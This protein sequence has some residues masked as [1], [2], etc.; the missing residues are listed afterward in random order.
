MKL[1][2]RDFTLR[3]KIL[4]L[5]LLVILIA[6]CYYQ[7]VHVP[8]SDS[9]EKEADRKTELETELQAVNERIALFEKMQKELDGITTDGTLKAMPSYNN[10]K[11]VTKLLND[12]LGNL[13]YNIRLT[14]VKRTNDLVRRQISL[15]FD[16]PDFESVS[17]VFAGLT[18]SEYRCLLSDVQF[19]RDAYA[20]NAL[21]QVDTGNRLIRVV[22]TVTFYE[23][24]VDGEADS[25]LEEAKK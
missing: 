23:T 3:E 24:M 5:I 6:L 11:N 25:G 13:G 2:S 19:A 22:A 17:A 1:L 12:V 20:Y 9:L 10:G 18:G 16:A 8:V 14:S 4:I 7:F 21:T 15:Q